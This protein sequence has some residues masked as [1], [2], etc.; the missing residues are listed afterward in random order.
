[1][2]L[3]TL[4]L[5]LVLT[6]T[7]MG[8][9]GMTSNHDAGFAAV[10]FVILLLAP[11]I[12]LVS[13][14]NAPWFVALL[15]LVTV[16]VPA[17][18]VRRFNRLVIGRRYAAALLVSRMIV[19]LHPFGEWRYQHRLMRALALLDRGQRDRAI[20]QLDTLQATSGCPPTTI[21]S[22]RMNSARLRGEWGDLLA[23]DMAG[24]IDHPVALVGRMRALGELGRIPELIGAYAQQAIR[25]AQARSQRLTS[26]SFLPWSYLQ[27]YLFAFTG[28]PEPAMRLLNGPLSGFPRETREFWRLTA[29]LAQGGTAAE[30]ARRTLVALQTQTKDLELRHD[31]ARRLD[32]APAPALDAA[33][34]AVLREAEASLSPTAPGGVAQT[35]TPRRWISFLLRSGRAT[36]VLALLNIIAF[37]LEM[38]AGNTEDVRVLFQLGGLWPPAVLQ[39]GEWWRLGTALFL[40]AG[41]LHI[42]LNMLAL[43]VL[44]PQIERLYGPWRM[45]LIYAVAGLGSMVVVLGVTELHWIPVELLIGAS[46]AI[47][48]LLGAVAAWLLRLRAVR[49]APGV[50]FRLGQVVLIM[51]LQAMFDIMTPAVS[52][53]G[54]A[55]G[56]V[57]GFVA[58][59]LVLPRSKF[60][61]ELATVPS[62]QPVSPYHVVRI[63]AASALAA[64]TGWLYS[65]S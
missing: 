31:I 33:A 29:E 24:Q 2:D 8:L 63:V 52:F 44:G 21:M 65:V 16:L 37:V 39:G 58:G 56:A 11:L 20:A 12:V 26:W 23:D 64:L 49:P 53:T 4:L 6:G 46:G 34:E 22:A 55:A 27:L 19:L 36:L 1:M 51:V 9:A 57:T 62:Q 40:H 50:M 30:D 61:A 54:H 14:R 5:W 48:G 18:L 10:L 25:I 32:M 45:L 28:R 41:V 59:W 13:P 15:W 3:T 42:G 43:L 47:M 17:L 7:V 60:P 35:A 38:R